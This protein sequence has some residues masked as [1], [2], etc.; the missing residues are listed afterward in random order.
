MQPEDAAGSAAE[1]SQTPEKDE[2]L[3]RRYPED[4]A[5]VA[6]RLYQRH[7]RTAVRIARRSGANPEEAEDAVAEAFVRILGMLADGRGPRRAFLRYLMRTVATVVRER[8]SG[9]APQDPQ[10]PEALPLAETTEA[11]VG[12]REEARIVTRAYQDLPPRWRT[13]LWGLDAEGR[14]PRELAAELEM[15]PNAVSQ[16]AVRARERLREGYLS[17]YALRPATGECAEYA[18]MLPQLVRGRLTSAR[19]RRLLRHLE[20]C[21]RCSAEHLALVSTS[22]LMRGWVLPGMLLGGVLLHGGQRAHALAAVGAASGPVADGAASPRG[23]AD[24]PRHAPSGRAHLGAGHPG[25]RRVRLGSALAAVAL[26][27]STVQLPPE[28]ARPSPTIEAEISAPS[29]EADAPSSPSRLPPTEFAETET[30]PRAAAG[31]PAAREEAERPVLVRTVLAARTTA[32]PEPDRGNGQGIRGEGGSSG[33]AGPAGRADGSSSPVEDRGSAVPVPQASFSSA[34]VRPADAEPEASGPSAEPAEEPVI[35][36]AAA[37]VPAQA[38]PETDLVP[39]D[40]DPGPVPAAQRPATGAQ[41]PVLPDPVDPE[42][43]PE[44][45]PVAAGESASEQDAGGEAAVED[46][47][48]GDA[49]AEDAAGPQTPASAAPADL[50]EDGQP[51][52][53]ARLPR[54]AGV[55]VVEETGDEGLPAGELPMGEPRAYAPR[56]AAPCAYAPRAYAPR[57]YGPRAYAPRA[58]APRAASARP[59]P[60]WTATWVVVRWRG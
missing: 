17:H 38:Q 22:D 35:R 26:F 49:V 53:Q 28:G 7:A 31:A 41:S 55:G 5:G 44:T 16:A 59:I 56:A 39:I 46:A 1:G 54:A 19:R 24:P 43:Q 18:P 47:A 48:A 34:Q 2:A 3:L 50:P 27:A 4:P 42:P 45:G 32:S 52:P 58:A 6:E 8:R 30:A 12:R 57:A 13:I 36:T 9:P 23:I 21:P 51:V 37:A 14:A 33:E 15:T 60:V 11:V 10:S 25:W 29:S 40:V 20:T